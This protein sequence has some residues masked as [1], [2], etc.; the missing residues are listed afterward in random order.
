MDDVLIALGTTIKVAGSQQ[1]FRG[2]G[3][4]VRWAL[5]RAARMAGATRLGVI[6][7]MGAR[8]MRGR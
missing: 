6:S 8:L 3:P 1:D 5:A 4:S 2:A 7:A